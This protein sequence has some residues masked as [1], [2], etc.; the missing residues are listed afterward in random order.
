MRFWGLLL[1][2]ALAG[3]AT[4][5]KMGDI[6][7]GMSKDDVTGV[8]GQ[9]YSVSSTDGAEYFHYRLAE[10]GYEAYMTRGR[11]KAPYVVRFRNGKV[12]AYGPERVVVPVRL[13]AGRDAAGTHEAAH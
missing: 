3:C 4:A 12:D 1:A 6:T 10:S 5:H 8:L 9:P 2:T 7:L 13:Q 11:A